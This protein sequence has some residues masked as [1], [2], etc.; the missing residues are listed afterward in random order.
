MNMV[1][2]TTDKKLKTDLDDRHIGPDLKDC[3]DQLDFLTVD[4]EFT[5]AGIYAGHDG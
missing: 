4:M 3:E 1:N 5:R 2:E